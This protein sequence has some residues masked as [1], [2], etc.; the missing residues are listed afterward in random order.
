MPLSS[1]SVFV[2]LYNK[3]NTDSTVNGAV[4]C[5]S[6]ECSK[7]EVSDSGYCSNDVAN[8][9]GDLKSEIAEDGLPVPVLPVNSGAEATSFNTEAVTIEAVNSPPLPPKTL[10]N[11]HRALMDSIRGGVRLR[12]DNKP[13]PLHTS[14]NAI[15]IAESQY[16]TNGM[17]SQCPP[18][19]S[20][21]D[22]NGGRNAVMASIIG[23]VPLRS[24]PANVPLSAKTTRQTNRNTF[25]C[26][27]QATL[28]REK[29]WSACDD[30]A[31][32]VDRSYQSFPMPNLSPTKYQTMPKLNRMNSAVKPIDN[33]FDSKLNLQNLIRDEIQK[34]EPTFLV[35]IRRIVREEIQNSK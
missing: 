24:S 25:L 23:G 10:N 7:S 14:S 20:R 21:S 26:N 8:A 32:Q 22:L 34:M 11:G 29:K 4:L 15:T 28:K 30:S 35:Q 12:S 18:S 3:L 13:C 19:T 31:K 2:N 9:V 1:V 17:G 27:L 33:Q 6:I 5:D 16:P